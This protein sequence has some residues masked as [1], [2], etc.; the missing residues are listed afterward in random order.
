MVNSKENYRRLN[1]HTCHKHCQNKV[2]SA[3]GDE[4]GHCQSCKTFNSTNKLAN[5]A[6]PTIATKIK[7]TLITNL[8]NTAMAQMFILIGSGL[9]LM[10]FSVWAAVM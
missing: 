4:I 1:E 10:G 9:A 2:Q 3:T 8:G 7:R 6:Q 5:E